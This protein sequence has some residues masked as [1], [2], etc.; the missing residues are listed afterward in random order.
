MYQINC[1]DC[2]LIYIGETSQNLLNWLQQHKNSKKKITDL[3]LSLQTTFNNSEHNIDNLCFFMYY[4]LKKI[5]AK[6]RSYLNI[7]NDRTIYK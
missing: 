4:I 6:Y 5:Y 2:T 3:K 7:Y 1:I